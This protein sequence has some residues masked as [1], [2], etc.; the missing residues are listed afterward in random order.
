MA[1]KNTQQVS[2]ESQVAA[3]P[4]S[5]T[6]EVSTEVVPQSDSVVT[7][8]DALN[9]KL[10]SLFTSIKEVQTE[11]KTLEKEYGKVLKQCT[12]KGGKKSTTKRAPS[13]FAKP[14]KLS[15]E[16]CAFLNLPEGTEKARTD[17]TKLLHE[18]IKTHNLQ[19]EKDKRTI[20]PNDS[21]RKIMSI[22]DNADKLTYFNL[23][24]C[25]KHHFDSSA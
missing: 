17:V 13:G 12:K 22:P 8:F 6:E 9:K 11:L 20:V 16:L 23:Q 3:A 14:C 21:L 15:K 5:Q 10:A 7:K 25:I 19:A 4:S 2:S 1:K 24:T 18:Y